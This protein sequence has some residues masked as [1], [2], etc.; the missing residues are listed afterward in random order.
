M[1]YSTLS[2]G[3]E[4]SGKDYS[5]RR[6][7]LQSSFRTNRPVGILSTDAD[8]SSQALHTLFPS[9]GQGRETKTS[10]VIAMLVPSPRGRRMGRI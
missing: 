4:H 5:G 9:P 1:T 3:E 6:P 2:E 8:P 7:G 10:Q